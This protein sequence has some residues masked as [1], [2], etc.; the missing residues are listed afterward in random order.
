VCRRSK[1]GDYLRRDPLEG[2]KATLEVMLPIR[3]GHCQS[4]HAWTAEVEWSDHGAAGRPAQIDGETAELPI[5][6][7]REL[8][9]R[10]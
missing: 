5:Q 8:R 4:L 6:T 9:S 7:D 3:C 2:R 1:N 10:A